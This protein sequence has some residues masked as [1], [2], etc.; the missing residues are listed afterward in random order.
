MPV[1]RMKTKGPDQ[2]IP[3]QSGLHPGIVSDILLVIKLDK[4][5]VKHRE[6]Q[7]QRDHGQPDAD[8]ASFFELW[9]VRPHG[10][11]MMRRTGFFSIAKAGNVQMASS[12]RAEKKNKNLLTILDFISE[13]K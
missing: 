3:S 9:I 10:V 12:V 11:S 2:A 4:T 1:A 7:G 8:E 6:I 13:S 5:V